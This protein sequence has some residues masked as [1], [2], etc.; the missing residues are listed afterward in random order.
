M[1][2][3]VRATP[4]GRG[5]KAIERISPSRIAWLSTY[6]TGKELLIVGPSGAGKTTFGEYLRLGILQPEGKQEM[7]YATTKSPTFSIRMGQD[8]TIMLNVR[9]AVDTPGQVGPLQ[10]ANLAGKRKPHAVIIILDT[11]KTVSATIGWLRLFCDRLDTVLRKKRPARRRLSEIAVV[12]NKRDK[13]N[14]TKLSKVKRSVQKVLGD[15]LSVVLGTETVRSIPV[16]ACT[17]VKINRRRASIGNVI[18][19]LTERLATRG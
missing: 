11:S 12:L 3:N 7:T 15:H 14:K 17:S 10:H 1:D 8:G 18:G 6:A 19:R 13:V 2:G 9:R 16:V 4:A 5:I